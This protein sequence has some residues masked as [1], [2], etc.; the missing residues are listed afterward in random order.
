MLLDNNI[1]YK[2]EIVEGG[3]GGGGVDKTVC[4]CSGIS[5]DE[6]SPASVWLHSNA[7]IWK[8]VT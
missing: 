7:K 3:G 2:M 6:N 5:F 4:V 1:L 8:C